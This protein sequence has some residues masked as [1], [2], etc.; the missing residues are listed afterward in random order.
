[1]YVTDKLLLPSGWNCT[2]WQWWHWAPRLHCP[3]VP[4]VSYLQRSGSWFSQGG[5]PCRGQLRRGWAPHRPGAGPGQVSQAWKYTF[6]MPTYTLCRE[7]VV[8]QSVLG[9]FFEWVTTLGIE[10]RVR[11]DLN[12]RPG[13]SLDSTPPSPQADIMLDNVS[14]ATRLSLP[15]Q[16]PL[17]LS[18]DAL[19]PSTS[20]LFTNPSVGTPAPS[21]SAN[22]HDYVT[23]APAT[24]DTAAT[25]PP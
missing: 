2:G 17:P 8:S 20:S 19:A 21:S 22:G 5:I 4:E 16:D 25:A 13:S 6:I 23:P 18:C 24:L 3:A 14:S 9:Q 10:D 12:F 1:M 7:Y 15:S 11:L